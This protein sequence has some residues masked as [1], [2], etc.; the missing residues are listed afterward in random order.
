MSIP[1]TLGCC[2]SLVLILS[3]A[4]EAQRIQ[5]GTRLPDYELSVRAP[6]KRVSGTPG[7]L[8]IKDR[9]C[10]NLA[11]R[12]DRQQIVDAAVQ[13]WA[14]FG[15]TRLDYTIEQ[16]SSRNQTDRRRW[17]LLDPELAVRVAD[18]IAGYWAAAPDSSWILQRQNERWE[19]LGLSARWRDPW[20]AAFI[21]WV[22]CESGLGDEDRFARAIAHHTYIDQAILARETPTQSKAYVA[23]DLGEQPVLPGDLLCRGSRPSYHSLA[24]RRAHLGAGA[25]THCDIVVRVD[26]QM[27]AFDVIGGNVR[28]TVGMKL[29]P[30][31]RDAEGLI[32]PAPF[33][34]S[35]IFAHLKLNADPVSL[36]ALSLSP[37]M[38]A[39]SCTAPDSLAALT[40]PHS[41]GKTPASHC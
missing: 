35:R 31:A 12:P 18:R 13:E 38:Q 36:D 10:S 1:Q 30:A 5:P 39:I 7:N 21:S 3:G 29:L 14:Y 33:G 4:A 32:V 19:T 40:K 11:G 25:R 37:T 8:R 6:S 41:A 22:M 17:S 15:F 24:E 16:T 27:P 28:G 23:Y 9:S 34:S 2:L 20:S 26:E